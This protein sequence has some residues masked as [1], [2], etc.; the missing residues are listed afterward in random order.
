MSRRYG[1]N[2]KRRARA[3]IAALMERSRELYAGQIEN[4][5]T[6][7]G[8][9]ATVAAKEAEL[10][11]VAKVLGT[12]FIG[13][14]PALW[15]LRDKNQEHLFRA[16][17]SDGDVLMHTMRTNITTGSDRPDYMVH[18]HAELAGECVGYAISE[19]ALRDGPE[20][21]IVCKISDEMGRLLM[22]ELRKKFGRSRR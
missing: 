11:H 14:K 6:I 4:Q 8:L 17:V 12:N 2:Q 3:Q 20:D 10:A 19:C 7:Q 15:K 21:Y 18:F 1:R 9:S 22:G 16:R 5:R 13:L